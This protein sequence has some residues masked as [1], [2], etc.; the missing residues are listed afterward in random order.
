MPDMGTAVALVA[1]TD[2]G[3]ITTI[4]TVALALVTALH[5]PS[6]AKASRCPDK[7]PRKM[8]G[9]FIPNLGDYSEVWLA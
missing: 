4:A 7:K 2:W 6:F 8:Q 5:A 1:A 3:E 9:Y